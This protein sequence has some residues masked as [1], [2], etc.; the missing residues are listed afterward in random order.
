MKMKQL[1]VL[2]AGIAIATVMAEAK[3]GNGNGACDQTKKQTC[4]Q[5]CTKDCSQ[6]ESQDCTGCSAQT[7]KQIRKKDGTGAKAGTGACTR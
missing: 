1:V 4:T 2:I 6:C 7:K 3:G 5:E